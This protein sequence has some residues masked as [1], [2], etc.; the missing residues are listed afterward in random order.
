MRPPASS[1]GALKNRQGKAFHLCKQLSS[2]SCCCSSQVRYAI[3]TRDA[4]SSSIPHL[5][6]ET[7][8]NLRPIF[9]RSGFLVHVVTP[10]HCTL[11]RVRIVLTFVG[12]T[13]KTREENHTPV[14]CMARDQ[15]DPTRYV[16]TRG[17]TMLALTFPRARRAYSQTRICTALLVQRG[18]KCCI[19][20]EYSASC[21]IKCGATSD[22]STIQGTKS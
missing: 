6:F 2:S 22:G 12:S 20:R 3:G 11:L 19:E 18:V 10:L 8:S 9:Y 15:P 4:I 5:S 16:D 13:K 21:K 7:R 1:W 17:A 14:L